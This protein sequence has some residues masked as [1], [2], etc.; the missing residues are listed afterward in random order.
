MQWRRRLVAK[1]NQTE[2]EVAARGWRISR[3]PFLVVVD[4]GIHQSIRGNLCGEM[5]NL[6]GTLSV[7]GGPMLTANQRKI[8]NELVGLYHAQL[9]L[10]EPTALPA[11]RGWTIADLQ[12]YDQR[13]ER[14]AKLQRQLVESHAVSA[15]KLKASQI[16]AVGSWGDR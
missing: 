7:N 16:V 8:C 9:P 11:G 14:I 2:D 15:V 12:L 13:A 5:F 6:S 1:A 10:V 3:Q 4:L